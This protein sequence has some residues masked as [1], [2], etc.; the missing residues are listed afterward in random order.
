MREA[1]GGSGGG[2]GLVCCGSVRGSLIAAMIFFQAAQGE[3]SCGGHG[4]GGD[5]ELDIVSVAVEVATM[6]TDD[7]PK[8]KVWSMVCGAD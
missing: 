3:I 5:V 1:V 6:K 2:W 8:W 7:R 4:F